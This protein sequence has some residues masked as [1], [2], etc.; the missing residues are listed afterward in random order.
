M[1]NLHHKA[2]NFGL[3]HNLDKTYNPVSLRY[4]ASRYTGTP[5]YKS[6]FHI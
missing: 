6:Y 3:V 1:D 2:N 5:R 4:A